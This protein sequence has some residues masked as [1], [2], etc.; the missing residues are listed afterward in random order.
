MNN[1]KNKKMKKFFYLHTHHIMRGMTIF[2]FVLIT[3]FVLISE[4]NAKTISCTNGI[5]EDGITEC[6]KCG[7]NCNWSYEEENKHLIINGNGDMYNYYH[8]GNGHYLDKN[9]NETPWVNFDITSLKINGLDSVGWNSFFSKKE[10]TQLE[11]GDSIKELYPGA[12]QN[13]GLQNVDIP[14]SVTKID[15]LAITGSNLEEII[16]TDQVTTI[17]KE[18]FPQNTK[19]ICRGTDCEKV[20][21]LLQQ[22]EW[23]GNFSL[24]DYTNCTSTNYFWNGASCIR[25]PD[26][27]KRKCCNSCKDMGGWCNRVRYTPAEA[28]QVLKDEG[29]IITITFKK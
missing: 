5:R 7:D 4:S 15:H 1:L 26:L 11:L 20:K 19:I 25:E 16:L 9:N 23:T 17:S 21:N 8:E 6:L 13:T 14:D 28:A 24:A 18:A 27:T 10:L 29:N 12:F 2:I 22:A 3:S